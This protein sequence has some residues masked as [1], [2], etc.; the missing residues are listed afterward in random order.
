MKPNKGRRPLPSE[1]SSLTH[2]EIAAQTAAFLASGG[3]VKELDQIEDPKVAQAHYYNAAGR[4][5]AARYKKGSG[6]KASAWKL[7]LLMG[8]LML[9]RSF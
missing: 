4:I 6:K 3:E 1:R 8:G 7:R 2:D 9:S 5:T